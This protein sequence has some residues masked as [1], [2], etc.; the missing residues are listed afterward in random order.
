RPARP[1]RASPFSWPISTRTARPTSW[2]PTSPPTT[3]R[4]FSTPPA[5]PALSASTP[6]PATALTPIPSA[7]WR[8][9]STAT[10]TSTSPSPSA[11]PPP[12]DTPVPADT[13]TDYRFDLLPGD[14]TG[15]F[16]TLQRFKVGDAA[17]SG[18]QTP[19]SIGVG[20]FNL[21]NKP[22]LVIG[23]TN[24]LLVTINGSTG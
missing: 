13:T 15:S 21:D 22:D 1:T 16:G 23:G 19:S 4:C 20:L 18:L 24:G 5:P 7:W 14:G 8:P 6:A 9:T 11:P 10:A 12:P 17:P 2:S 3:S